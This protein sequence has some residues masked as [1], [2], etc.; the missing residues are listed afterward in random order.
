MKAVPLQKLQIQIFYE[1][2]FAVL[3]VL[4]DF[5]QFVLLNIV[6]V[7]HSYIA[8]K[9]IFNVYADVLNNAIEVLQG[10]RTSSSNHALGVRK[11]L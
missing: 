4:D 7:S 11:D 10:I 9:A 5:F 2:S 1:L 6:N 8:K 3:R